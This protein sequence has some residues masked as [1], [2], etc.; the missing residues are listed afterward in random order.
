MSLV[1][2]LIKNDIKQMMKDCDENPER[3]FLTEFGKLRQR[4][5]YQEQMIT[6]DEFDRICEE[7]LEKD[8]E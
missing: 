5:V 3:E 6:I 7:I 8:D 4:V 2:A 1:K